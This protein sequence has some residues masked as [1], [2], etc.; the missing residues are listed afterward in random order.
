MLFQYVNDCL[1]ERQSSPVRVVSAPA[2]TAPAAATTS[3]SSGPSLES[4]PP[5]AP[6][7]APS[8]TSTSVPIQRSCPPATA[9]STSSSVPIQRSCPPAT[10]A[11]KSTSVPT[12]AGA[13]TKSRYYK[14]DNKDRTSFVIFFPFVRSTNFG[15]LLP[16]KGDISISSIAAATIEKIKRHVESLTF[17]LEN[18]VLFF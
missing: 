17:Q 4:C 16:K 5:T 11:S 14:Y 2:A 10:A 12:A 18:E 8:S 15:D 13:S 9:S 1:L 6:A 7:A 3:S